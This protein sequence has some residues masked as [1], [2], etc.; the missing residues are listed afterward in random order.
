MIFVSSMGNYIFL[1]V[2][3]VE[4]LLEHCLCSWKSCFAS[5]Y[6]SY[7]T[8]GAR[9]LFVLLETM[10]RLLLSGLNNSLS[11][12]LVRSSG[13]YAPPVVLKVIQQL[14]HVFI[15]SLGNYI[16]PVVMRVDQML[17]HCLCS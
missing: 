7:T 10:L 2:M 17:E 16:S 1:I 9:S 15:S 12:V 13:N 6:E 4:Q 11:M 14:E 5:R 3:R 8:A